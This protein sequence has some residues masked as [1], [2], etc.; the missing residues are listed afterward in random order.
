M[1]KGLDKFGTALHLRFREARTG[2]LELLRGALTGLGSVRRH[3]AK[4]IRLGSGPDRSSF[5]LSSMYGVRSSFRSR[6][7]PSRQLV[8][9]KRFLLPDQ[10]VA[11]S[12]FRSSNQSRTSVREWHPAA[13]I[14]GVMIGVEVLPSPFLTALSREVA[15]GISHNAAQRIVHAEVGA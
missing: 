1:V 4:R 8:W 12:C 2:R 15:L 14:A 7:R 13:R 9:T 10:R 6:W 3:I 5:S 11:R